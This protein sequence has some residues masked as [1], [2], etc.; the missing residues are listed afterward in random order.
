VGLQPT[1]VKQRIRN[2]NDAENKDCMRRP[3]CSNAL[4]GLGRGRGG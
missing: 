4:D 3:M 2:R 1:Q